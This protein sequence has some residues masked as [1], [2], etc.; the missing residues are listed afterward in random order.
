[1]PLR[2]DE[3][4]R[5]PRAFHVRSHRKLGRHRT[6]IK[7]A[8]SI[9]NWLISHPAV[10]QVDF[11]KMVSGHSG[12][13]YTHRIKITEHGKNLEVML[14]AKNCAQAF[15]ITLRSLDSLEEIKEGISE[16]WM[17]LNAAND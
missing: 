5:G 14:V 15:T 11:G 17:Q 2:V 9:M 13:K 12:R 1:M 8:L 16:R 4:Y 10:K 6:V 7:P 3:N